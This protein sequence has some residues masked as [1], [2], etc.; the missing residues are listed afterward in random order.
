MTLQQLRMLLPLFWTFFRI[1]P[2]TFGGGYA[3]ISLIEHETVTKR[4]WIDEQEFSNLI[5]IAGS[6]PGGVGV[7]AAAFIG[8]RLAGIGG[9]VVSIIGITLPTFLIVLGLS[10]LYISMDGNPKVAAAMKGIQ[11][12]VIALIITA[13]YKMAKSSL[14][15]MATT[16]IA[17]LTFAILI[18]SKI[19]PIFVIVAG[20]IIGIAFIGIK[21]LLGMNIRTE[22]VVSQPK[23]DGVYLEYYI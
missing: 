14:F 2:A 1:G 18:L 4:N 5:S 19:N 22:K 21:K 11:A 23:D 3:M 10:F 8:Y 16:V 12:A 6:A 17:I 7:N 20:L 15:D 9:A 13:A